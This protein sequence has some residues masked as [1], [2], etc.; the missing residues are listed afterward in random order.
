[1]SVTL[2]ALDG[3]PWCETVHDALVDAGVEYE[4]VWVDALH[5][6]RNE[7]KRVS[8]QREVPV[9]VDEHRGVTMPESANILEYV[10]RTL[11]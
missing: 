10:D 4:T 5:S 9:L 1:M 2:Y 7:V 3:C 8:G 6:D 11:T